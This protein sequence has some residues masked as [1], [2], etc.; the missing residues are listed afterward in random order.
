MQLLLACKRS[1]HTNSPDKYRDQVGAAVCAAARFAARS[2]RAADA[3]RDAWAAAIAAADALA[4][5]IGW[6]RPRE[7][8]PA[9]LALPA[10]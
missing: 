7:L 9:R 1:T 8:G 4:G 3:M 5:T 10:L 6:A 2:A